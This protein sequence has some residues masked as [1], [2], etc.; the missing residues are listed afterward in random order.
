MSIR[1]MTDFFSPLPSSQHSLHGNQHFNMSNWIFV[2]HY[3]S[4]GGWCV[5]LCVSDLI[6]RVY[7]NQYH[8]F[9]LPFHIN[10]IALRKQHN[11]CC[12]L[13]YAVM[14]INVSAVEYFKSLK[15]MKHKKK[16][17]KRHMQAAYVLK[18]KLKGHRD[19][20]HCLGF[21]F[22]LNKEGELKKKK[23]RNWFTAQIWSFTALRVQQ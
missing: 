8:L 2:P 7:C 13:T 10:R 23:N 22:L 18:K 6:W 19:V 1:R 20:S 21:K 15:V 5:W 4:D 16:R 17:K 3:M 14:D 9:S 12:Q 11:I